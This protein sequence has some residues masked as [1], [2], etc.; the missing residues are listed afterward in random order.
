[1]IEQFDRSVAIFEERRLELDQVLTVTNSV[2]AYTRYQTGCSGYDIVA[3]HPLFSEIQLR[4]IISGHQQSALA[5]TQLARSPLTDPDGFHATMQLHRD[6]GIGVKQSLGSVYK[7]MFFF[8]R[9]LQDN[10][11]RVILE[12]HPKK[13]QTLRP[14]ESM[15]KRLN[16]NNNAVSALI[17]SQLP[18]YIPW[19]YMWR[20]MRN[21]VKE[22]CDFADRLHVRAGRCHQA[23][24]G[25]A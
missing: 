14:I 23:D 2:K 10:Y 3:L 8:I 13:G 21:K 5:V 6:L 22:G 24:R 20:D 16:E 1:M 9:A 25:V 15:E 18:D 7:C 17:R 4:A 19:F 12:H 11:C